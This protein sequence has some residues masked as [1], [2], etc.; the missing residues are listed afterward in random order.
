MPANRKS[1][2]VR[3]LHGN[4]PRVNPQVADLSA[5]N[6]PPT[7]FSEAARGEWERVREA[8]AR[9]DAWLQTVDRAALIAYCTAYATFEE[10]V[11]SRFH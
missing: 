3:E 7:W 1:N 11:G 5:H 4:K 6:K 8:C 9:Y 10:A 2:K